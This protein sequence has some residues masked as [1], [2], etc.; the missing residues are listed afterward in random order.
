MK[1]GRTVVLR[2]NPVNPYPAVEKLAQTLTRS[3]YQVTVVGW[4]RTSE[5]KECRSYIKLPSG[6]VPIVRFGIPA[7]FD[8]GFRKN[9][10]PMMRFQLQLLKWLFQNRKNYDVI[11]AFDLDTGLAGCLAAKLLAKRFVYQ[12]QDFYA[13]DRFQ[14]GSFL[15]NVVH[16]MELFVINKADAVTVCTEERIQQIEG[17]FPKILK[18]I[19]NAPNGTKVPSTYYPVVPNSDRIKIAYV[20]VLLPH[21]LL[22]EL[23]DFVR[24]D[25]RFELHIGGYGPLKQHIEEQC[26]N[27][28]R[29]VF[30]GTIPHDQTLCLEQQCDIMTA[31]YENDIF[32][33]RY[34]APN[35][36]YEAMLL[37]KPIL[38]CRNTGWDELISEN[39]IGALIEC[40]EKGIKEGLEY[41]LEKRGEWPEMS[42]RSQDIF[43][44]K[45]AW[46]IME[47]RILQIYQSI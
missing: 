1:N 19:H 9:L 17:S 2:S 14:A 21:R 23:L 26:V 13:G 45:Y 46:P 3:G 43:N 5:Q 7:Q 35:K 8:G 10:F 33:H 31:L 29:I 30:Y 11:H 27:C 20:G 34:C 41:L 36:L 37:G 24:K 47:E 15:Y 38:M 12:I 39:G 44:T 16:K 6:D 42:R 25:P 32:N 4:D 18:V 22:P 40:N 28:D